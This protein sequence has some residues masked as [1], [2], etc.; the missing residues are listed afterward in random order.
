MSGKRRDQ[1]AIA[2]IWTYIRVSKGCGDDG[3][4]KEGRKEGR[5]YK[6]NN[7]EPV[8]QTHLEHRKDTLV[9]TREEG[10]QAQGHQY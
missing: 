8:V 5:A 4:G 1:S 3:K 6:A 9:D 2:R 7:D 10:D